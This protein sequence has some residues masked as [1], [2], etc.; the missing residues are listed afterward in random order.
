MF[1]STFYSFLLLSALFIGCNTEKDDIV[2]EPKAF[3]MDAV[4]G[5]WR[6]ASASS[7]AAGGAITIP[8]LFDATSPL[9]S[10]SQDAL[11]FAIFGPNTT[12][13]YK[14]NN[15]FEERSG[16]YA[17][18]P[19]TTQA[20]FVTATGTYVANETA[21]TLSHTFNAGSSPAAL[22]RSAQVVSVNA[23]TLVIKF[24]IVNSGVTAT[25]TFTY[26]KLP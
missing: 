13:E 9:I 22:N 15:I 10:S 3:S 12:I 11:A 24:D 16:L 23:T 4:I 21:G 26:T 6:I 1:K 7:V 20:N 2:P 19:T 14:R 5:R 18:P 17:T 8:N 25:N